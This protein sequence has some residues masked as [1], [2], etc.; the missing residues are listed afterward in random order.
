[1]TK[2]D[3]MEQ[4]V[5]IV[6]AVLQIE[7]DTKNEQYFQRWST[8]KYKDPKKWQQKK[9]KLLAEWLIDRGKDRCINYKEI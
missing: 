2:V 9:A 8:P 1:M 6:E 7:L 5:P 4:L 3:K